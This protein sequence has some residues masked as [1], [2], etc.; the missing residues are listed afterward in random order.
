M[1][2][3]FKAPLMLLEADREVEAR[4]ALDIAAS[5]ITEDGVKS[6]DALYSDVYPQWPLLWIAWAASSLG[7]VDMARQC[8]QRVRRYL[9]PLTTSGLIKTPYA[10]GV[11]YEADFLATATVAKAALIVQDFEAARAAGDSLLRA[12]EANRRFAEEGRFCLRWT[13]AGGFAEETDLTLCVLQ[14]GHGQ[15]YFA[16]GFPASVLLELSAA[17]GP[18]S[19]AYQAGALELLG[20]LRACDGVLSSLSAHQV[21]RAAA[22][23]QEADLAQGIVEH[24]LS[25]QVEGCFHWDAGA[26]DAID[27]TAEAA[28]CMLQVARTSQAPPQPL[29]PQLPTTLP[30]QRPGA[31]EKEKLEGTPQAAEAQATGGAHS[32]QEVTLTQ[33]TWCQNCGSFLWGLRSQ[34]LRCEG[35]FL[36]VCSTCASGTKLRTCRAAE[37]AV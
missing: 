33:F 27:Q 8:F 10:W 19:E 5:F 37:C 1:I 9:H 35:C 21:A 26:L 29:Q 34:G 16:M 28:I 17:L 15:Q 31:A 25:A 6:D 7:Q 12:V 36:I 11:D 22:L 18:G 14:R 4:R 32:F 3:Y 20:F 23:A 24:L 13:H 2:F 30:P